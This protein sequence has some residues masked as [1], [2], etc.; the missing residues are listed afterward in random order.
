M[1]KIGIAFAALAAGGMIYVIWRPKSLL[2]FSWFDTLGIGK[3]IAV[4]RLFTHDHFPTMPSWIVYSLPNALWLFSGL[5]CFHSVWDPTEHRPLILWCSL[6]VVIA[7]LW[8][9]AQLAHLLPGAF[10]IGDIAGMIAACALCYIV[11]NQPNRKEV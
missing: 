6:F 9:I 5:L 7:F 10:D 1:K 11:V 4:I 3:P 2:M 8:E